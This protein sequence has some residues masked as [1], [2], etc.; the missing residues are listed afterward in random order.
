MYGHNALARD[1]SSLS[2][3]ERELIII[4][5]EFEPTWRDALLKLVRSL[6]HEKITGGFQTATRSPGGLFDE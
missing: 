3:D 5:R 2:P 1:I 6:H 4:Y